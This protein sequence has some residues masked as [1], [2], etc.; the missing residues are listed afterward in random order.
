[1][2]HTIR[3]RINQFVNFLSMIAVT[4]VCVFG[5][6]AMVVLFA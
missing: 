5:L 2:F 1:M 4:A 3:T 6:M